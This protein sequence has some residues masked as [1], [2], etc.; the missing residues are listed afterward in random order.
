MAN[1]RIQIFQSSFLVFR[2]TIGKA[3]SRLGLFGCLFNV[4]GWLSLYL[5]LQTEFLG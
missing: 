5:C 1:D 4:L 2:D 3:S